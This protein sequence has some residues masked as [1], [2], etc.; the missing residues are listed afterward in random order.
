LSPVEREQLG[1]PDSQT[2]PRWGVESTAGVD[3]VSLPIA[4][5][6]HAQCGFT[7]QAWAFVGLHLEVRI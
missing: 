5:G 2:P 3:F 7:N 6:A 1:L 4:L